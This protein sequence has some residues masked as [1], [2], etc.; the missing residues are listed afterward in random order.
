MRREFLQL[1]KIFDEKKH[2]IAGWLVS[3]KLD[4]QRAL[5][6]GGIT[7]GK[8]A[9]EV[10]WANTEKDFRLKVAPIA[11][12][13]WSRYGKVIRAPDW[14][15]DKLPPMILDGELYAGRSLFQFTESVVR[16]HTPIE[17][18]WEHIK[19]HVFDCLHPD[20]VFQRG[21]ISIPNFKKEIVPVTYPDNIIKPDLSF[22]NAR[23][24]HWLK[25]QQLSDIISIVEQTELPYSTTKAMESLDEMLTSVTDKGGEGLMLKNPSQI[26][27]P[28]RHNGL[29]KVKPYLDSEA[30]VTGFIWGDGKFSG[31]LGALVVTWNGRTFKLGTGF[32]DND[33]FVA[34]IN[35]EPVPFTSFTNSQPSNF[36]LGDTINFR[37]RELTDDGTPKEARYVRRAIA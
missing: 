10:P 17:S 24:Y 15:L 37:Y 8:P 13:L 32:N 18:E 3:E 26:W 5:W 22:S 2:G 27:T 4:G 25:E 31:M 9:T 1:A 11:T 34:H 23:T 16:K 35:E 12:G 14:W 33:R 30:T 28:K 6:D 36:S 20:I 7:R 29:L 19:F 21:T